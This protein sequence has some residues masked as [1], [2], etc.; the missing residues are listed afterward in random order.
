VSDRER[1]KY[2]LNEAC[3]FLN[4]SRQE[5]S[6][7]PED[8]T[9]ILEYQPGQ[10]LFLQGAPLY[11]YSIICEGAVKLVRRLKEGRKVIVAVLSPGDILGLTAT[12][13]GHFT[14]EAEAVEKTRV[15]FIDKGDFVRLLEKYPR[16][17]GALVQKLSDEVAHLQER[18][19]ATARQ[20]AR[21][22]LAYLLLQLA[23]SHGR[24]HPQ[25]TLIDL[26]LSR[27]ELAEMIGVARETASLTL[28]QLKSRGLIA[29]E[30]HKIVILDQAGLENLFY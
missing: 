28:G 6:F 8:F 26:A 2:C 4:V 25:G 5:M 22:K 16:L 18:L 14:L 9:R 17:A 10:T 1:C 21:S 24:V 7:H 29:L 27:A 13:Q 23:S 3:I 15:G 19:F 12:R 11:G 20:S 30:G